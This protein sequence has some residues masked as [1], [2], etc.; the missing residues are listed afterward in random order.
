MTT[1]KCFH[2]IFKLITESNHTNDGE[3]KEEKGDE[4]SEDEIE[5]YD[6]EDRFD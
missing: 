5:N 4:K 2:K 6:T 1:S 3:D